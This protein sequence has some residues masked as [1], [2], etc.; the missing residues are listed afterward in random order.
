VKSKAT[1]GNPKKPIEW[2]EIH[3][4]LDD[5]RAAVERGWSPGVKEKK[6]ILEA[7]ARTLAQQPAEPEDAEQRIEVIEFCLAYENYGIESS[8]VREAFP[9]VDIT[10]LPC[11]PPFVLGI[12]NVRGEIVS[13]LD[14]K[15]FFDLP[16]RGLTD[17][18]KVII[19]QSDSMV[20]GIL[21][22][23]IVGVRNIAKKEIQQRLPTL[24]GIRE[25]YLVGIT[26]NR[27]V[28]LDAAQLLSDGK[29]VVH[30]TVGA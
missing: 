3:R 11:T 25:D 22:D 13:V 10:R 5:L 24:T 21:A 9:L 23:F 14:L 1:G 7:R 16:E 28:I 6:K 4:R 29:I 19:L 17:F 27:T 12:I 15:K 20:F 18:N 8:F 30:E 2:Q 26:Q